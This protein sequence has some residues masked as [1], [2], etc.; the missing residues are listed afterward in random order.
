MASNRL[1]SWGTAQHVPGTP[2]PHAPLQQSWPRPPPRTPEQGDCTQLQLPLVLLSLQ[3]VGLMTAPWIW[4]AVQQ[5]RKQNKTLLQVKLCDPLLATPSAS[6]C[7]PARPPDTHLHCSECR[8][9]LLVPLPQGLQG[10][11][12]LCTWKKAGSN[13]KHK[14][15]QRAGQCMPRTHRH[16]VPFL[17]SGVSWIGLP[18]RARDGVGAVIIVVVR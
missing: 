12:V 1:H 14:Q 15:A 7:T 5:G 17:Y 10:G 3:R 9:E 8:L 13:D 6:L 4:P 11:T 2:P 18:R 16:R